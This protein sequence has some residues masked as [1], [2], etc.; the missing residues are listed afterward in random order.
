[1]F[2]P[3]DKA[4]YYFEFMFYNLSKD[5][6]EKQSTQNLVVIHNCFRLHENMT[7]NKF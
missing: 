6:Q 5:F 3:S 4:I 7:F 2:L 1:M